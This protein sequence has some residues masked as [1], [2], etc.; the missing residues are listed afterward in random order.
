MA[1]PPSTT[2][3]APTGTSPFSTCARRTLPTPPAIMIGLW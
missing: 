2:I 1:G 3:F